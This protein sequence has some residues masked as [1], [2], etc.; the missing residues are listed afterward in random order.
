MICRRNRANR[1]FNSWFFLNH[2]APRKNK[3]CRIKY[4]WMPD[5]IPFVENGLNRTKGWPYTIA[6]NMLIRREL[7]HTV[8]VVSMIIPRVEK[9]KRTR[10]FSRVEA[11]S[12]SQL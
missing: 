3:G 9:R 7:I 10:N 12:I 4:V 1:V 8:I 2:V 11:G 6:F 5:R